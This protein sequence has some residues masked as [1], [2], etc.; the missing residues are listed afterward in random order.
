MR[1]SV[2]FYR[3][4]L[5]MDLIYGGEEAFFSWLRVRMRNIRFSTWRRV[6]RLLAGG[7]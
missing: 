6:D 2:R 7:G 3:D 5:D 1:E 4:V